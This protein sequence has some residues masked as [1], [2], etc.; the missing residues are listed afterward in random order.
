MCPYPC[1]WSWT[2]A[3]TLNTCSFSMPP[4]PY[5]KGLQ[6]EAE[7]QCGLRLPDLSGT[8]DL[9]Q[10][11]AAHIRRLLAEDFH[12]LVFMLYR[13]DIPEQRLRDLLQEKPEEEAAV[14]I[15]SLILERL[16]QKMKTREQYRK[17]GEDTTDP[18][19]W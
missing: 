3:I 10:M 5:L 11:L 2:Q 18:E 12:Q 6:Q 1:V 15:C 7:R 9:R 14:L 8:A 4:D 19:R 13:I 17:Q 16:S